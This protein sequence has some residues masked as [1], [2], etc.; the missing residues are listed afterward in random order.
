MEKLFGKNADIVGLA[1][2]LGSDSGYMVNGGVAVLSGRGDIIQPQTLPLNLNLLIITEEKGVS[3]KECYAISDSEKKLPP[4]TEKALTAYINGDYDAFVSVIK[5]D[6]YS[7]SKKLLP[8]I[9]QNVNA[10]K[11]VGAD[12]SIMTGS[13]SAVYG[14]FKDKKARDLAYKKLLVDYGERLIKAKTL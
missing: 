14:I 1:N 5:N 10:L 3:T 7:A 4:C 11:S 8:V 13:G 6:L 9:E 12:A 2:T